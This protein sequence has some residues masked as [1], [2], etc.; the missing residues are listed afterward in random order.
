MQQRIVPEQLTILVVDDDMYILELIDLYLKNKGFQVLK[1]GSGQKA[2][3]LL[4]TNVVHLII[5]DIMLPQMSGWE[6]CQSVR[7]GSDVPILMLTAREGSEDKVKGLNLGADDYLVK[8]FDPNELVARVLALLRRAFSP[9]KRVVP[10]PLI[11]LGT[12]KI[13]T[14]R[15]VV[16]VRE[17]Y[18]ELTPREFQLL[19]VFAKHPNQVFNREQL[20]DLVWGEDYLGEDRVVDVFVTRLRSKLPSDDGTWSIQTVRGFGYK[21]RVE[22]SP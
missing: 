11:T 19:L 20:L 10:L 4:R 21:L 12:L 5:L 2:L 15:H 8:P 1:A 3:N 22:D 17:E 14:I 18:I 9:Q 6:V 16:T 7:E 13:N